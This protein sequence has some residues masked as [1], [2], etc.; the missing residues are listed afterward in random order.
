MH[1]DNGSD[2]FTNEFQNYFKEN[3]I[4]HL[5]SV[6]YCPQSNGKAERLNRILIEKASCMMKAAMDSSSRNSKLLAQ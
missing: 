3:G 2:Y 6:P 5:R 1:T 4:I